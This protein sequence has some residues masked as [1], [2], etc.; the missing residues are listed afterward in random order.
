M[1]RYLDQQEADEPPAAPNLELR[2]GP[3]RRCPDDAA[4]DRI[5]ALEARVAALEGEDAKWRRLCV[6]LERVL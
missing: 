2:P 3:G 6:Q 5:D 4:C 1:N